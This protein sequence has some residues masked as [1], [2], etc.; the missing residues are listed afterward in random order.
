[1]ISRLK[2][3]FGFFEA[4]IKAADIDGLNN[5]FWLVTEDHFEIG[6]VRV[7]VGLVG[8]AIK[9]GRAIKQSAA[10]RALGEIARNK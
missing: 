1:M 7:R 4:P 8:Q 6:I 3:K 10:G 2:Q 5:A 9:H